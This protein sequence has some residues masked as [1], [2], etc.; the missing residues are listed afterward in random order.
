MS[1]AIRAENA[2]VPVR[3]LRKPVATTPI[4]AATWW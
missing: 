3:G 4:M 2:L 1:S